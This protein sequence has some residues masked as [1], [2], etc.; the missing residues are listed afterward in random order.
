MQNLLFIATA[1]ILASG[2]K[3]HRVDLASST[4]SRDGVDTSKYV[5]LPFNNRTNYV[6]KE[7]R[8]APLSKDEVDRIEVYVQKTMSEC[9]RRAG[10]YRIF[11]QPV[12]KYMRQYIAIFNARGQKIVWVNLFCTD[13]GFNWH[14][15][16]YMVED[17]G[18]CYFNLK[19]NLA[20]RKVYDLMVNGIAVLIRPNSLV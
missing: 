5:I 20:T 15:Q 18:G 6:F 9:Q 3:E 16:V 19:I 7:G 13:D 12:D 14:K 1:F 17:G 4:S 11:P 10:K 2:H 8:P